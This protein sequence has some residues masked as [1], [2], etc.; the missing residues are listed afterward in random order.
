LLAELERQALEGQLEQ[1]ESTRQALIE[2]FGCGMLADPA[3]LTRFWKAEAA[4]LSAT[5]ETAAAEAARAAAARLL[6]TDPLPAPVTGRVLLE[7]LPVGYLGAVDGSVRDFP[8]ELPAGLHLVQVGTAPEHMVG[9][10]LVDLPPHLELA[11]DFELPVLPIPEPVAPLPEPEPVLERQPSRGKRILH[12]LV[13]GGAG[14]ALYGATFATKPAFYKVSEPNVAL[15]VT[16][17]ALVIGSIGV[18]AASGVLLVRGIAT[19][20]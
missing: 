16:N 15:G 2:A 17:N 8:A 10:R 7:K 19:A 12:A 13:V 9:A 20:P 18:G 1:A 5:G 11:L 14:A 3:Q 4:I 6:G